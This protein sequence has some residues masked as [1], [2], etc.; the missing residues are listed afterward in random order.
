MEIVLLN[1]FDYVE[2]GA[3]RVAHD[4]ARMLARRGHSV[5]MVTGTARD[6]PD[7]DRL[8]EAGVRVVSAGVH[9]IATDPRRLRAATAGLWNPA[10]RAVVRDVVASASPDAVFHIHT[11][12]KALSN[13]ALHALRPRSDRV[14]VTLHDYFTSCPN[15]GFFNYQTRTHCPLRAMSSACVGTNCDVRSY[16]QKLWRVGRQFVQTRLVHFPAWCQNVI[17]LSSLSAD[18][19]AG[20]LSSSVTVHHLP[21]PAPDASLHPVRPSTSRRFVMVGRLDPEKGGALLASA[22][23]RAG[24]EVRFIG[25]GSE[26]EAI[27]QHNP[28]A[29]VTG[30]LAG[31]VL[32]EEVRSA[33]V[34]V[35]PSLWLETDGLTV[36]EAAAQGVPSLVADTC[37]AAESIADEVTGLLFRGRDEIALAG[38]LERL[39]ND[40]GLV[41]RL[42]AAAHARI[43]DGSLS[44]DVYLD[45][46]EVIYQSLGTAPSPT[47]RTKDRGSDA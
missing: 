30:W 6:N 28:N 18:R 39:A 14:I 46:L 38:G 3:S 37:A 40:D 2:G 34:L 35:F 20:Y 36:K 45:A 47:T 25:D 1:D 13:S 15:G 16:G 33:R 29:T 10:A 17:A 7:R 23:A 22:A 44:S 19:L 42:G 32:L 21:N 41:D 8:S 4:S 26:R 27:A 5:T 11:W 12:T 43:A 31:S 24:T 9:D